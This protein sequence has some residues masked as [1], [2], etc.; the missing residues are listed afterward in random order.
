M[1]QTAV[2][3]SDRPRLSWL[4][5]PAGFLAGFLLVYGW[6]L[7][8]GH[9]GP[10]ELPPHPPAVPPVSS[11]PQAGSKNG[12]ADTSFSKTLPVKAA[13]D[14]LFQALHV[15]NQLRKP[16]GRLE[17]HLQECE[18][19]AA[20]SQQV[21]G[22]D[23]DSIVRIEVPPFRNADVEA[24]WSLA[25]NELSK[26]APGL[27]SYFIARVQNIQGQFLSHPQ[28]SGVLFVKLQGTRV[29]GEPSVQYWFFQTS[30]P[31]GYV[32]HP[33][34]TIGL[35]ENK[36]LPQGAAWLDHNSMKLPRRLKHLVGFKES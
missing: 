23:G 18:L 7:G 15:E 14:L 36:P 19:K 9:T 10:I 8:S 31:G 32:L 22:P 13:D 25:E 28:D 26:L 17:K 21:G 1:M 6:Q 35:P 33:D 29:P 3:T 2:A 34:G 4:P 12:G 16:I 20:R 5:L 27:Q 24:F 30:E 11:L